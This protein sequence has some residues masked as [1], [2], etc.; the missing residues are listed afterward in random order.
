MSDPHY[1]EPMSADAETTTT[2]KPCRSFWR[3]SFWS[4]L[5]CVGVLVYYSFGRFDT[6]W[7]SLSGW[8]IGLIL[9]VVAVVAIVYDRA[10]TRRRD[11]EAAGR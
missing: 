10:K 5:S 7:L 6:P 3:R 2:P 1:P 4:Y 9:A 8:Q 11:A